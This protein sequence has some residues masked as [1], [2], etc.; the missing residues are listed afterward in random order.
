MGG[1]RLEHLRQI[2]EMREWRMW[3]LRQVEERFLS[4]LLTQSQYTD[5]CDRIDKEYLSEVAS[6]HE[7]MSNLTL[8]Q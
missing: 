1:N 2:R 4:G 5:A 6:I 3:G 7:I 8:T